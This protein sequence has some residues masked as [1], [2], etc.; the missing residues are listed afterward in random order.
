MNM[1]YHEY[2]VYCSRFP[3]C[4]NQTHFASSITNIDTLLR[5]R[6]GLCVPCW[7]KHKKAK[8]DE[9]KGDAEEDED[10]E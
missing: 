5:S 1:P 7:E 2:L 6:L 9:K 10:D 4:M 3:K 8:E